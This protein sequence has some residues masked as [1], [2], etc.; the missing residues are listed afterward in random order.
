MKLK[1]NQTCLQGAGEDVP[2]SLPSFDLGASRTFRLLWWRAAG[3]QGA[4]TS[5]R[6]PGVPSCPDAAKVERMESREDTWGPCLAHQL[7]PVPLGDSPTLTPLETWVSGSRCS[8][9]WNQTHTYCLA[10]I[11][12]PSAFS[13]IQNTISYL[14]WLLEMIHLKCQTQRKNSVHGSHYFWTLG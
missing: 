3:S 8:G 4:S 10:Y 9:L 2:H 12:S 6:K 11:S 5:S 13:S 14:P 7:W 1:A